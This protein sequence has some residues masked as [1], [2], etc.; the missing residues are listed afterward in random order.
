[1]NVGT[2][3]VLYGAHAFWLHPWFV[4]VGWWRLFGVP[5][6]PWLWLAFFVHDLGYWGSLNMDGPEGEEHP[7]WGA[8]VLYWTQGTWAFLRQSVFF[9]RRFQTLPPI[10]W[11]NWRRRWATAHLSVAQQ[12]VVW[13]NEVMFHSR[14]L[15]KK[16]GAKPSRLCMADKLAL[17]ITP[18]WVYRWTAG[19][20][21]EIREYRQDSANP[22][23]GWDNAPGS[24]RDWY[25]SMQAYMRTWIDE[26]LDGREDTWT[27]DSREA[28]DDAG[29][30]K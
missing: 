4:M 2:K 15:A 8:G 29:V 3:S 25:D 11:W 9:E 30:W 19:L 22:S 27:P 21:G 24:D 14:F 18:W 10:R 6:T 23:K 7:R 12:D 16:Y 5:R 20:T 28:R 13:G 1:M 17:C 26:H